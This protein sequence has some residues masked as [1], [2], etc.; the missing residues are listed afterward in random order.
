[1]EK[2]LFWHQGLFLQPQHLQLKDQFD[3][4]RLT[5]YHTYLQPYLAGVSGL[6]IRASSLRNGTFHVN[7]GAF[8]FDDMTYAVIGENAVI[9]PRGF[10][11]VWGEGGK[12]LTVYIGI[13]RYDDQG[14]NVASVPSGSSLYDLNTR[15][16]TGET[17][18]TVNDLHQGGS[19]AKVKK[20]SCLL[21]IFFHPE[22]ER[23]GSY[24]LI[25]VAR[26]ERT[27]E[28]IRLSTTYVPPS[29]SINGSSLLT[30]LVREVL[31]Q[32]T[33]RGHELELHKKKRGIHNAEFG[34][35]D[36]VY[37]LALMTFNRYIPL[38]NHFLDGSDIHPWNV[39][40]ALRQ[41]IGELSSFSD[42]IDVHGAEEKGSNHLKEY[43]HYDLWTCFSGALGLISGLIDEI[44]AGPEYVIPFA[45][46]D[47]YYSMQLSPE[48]FDGN[49]HYYLVIRTNEDVK[50][51]LD[52]VDIG[53]KLSS[54][55]LLPVLVERSLPGAALE[56]IP[57]PPQELPRRSDFIYFK[58][59]SQC[60][61][62]AQVESDKTVS[63]YWEFPPEDMG[64][65][66]MIVRRR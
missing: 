57:S 56:Y 30:G 20:L 23:L 48:H 49:N 55:K 51:V 54:G 31:D 26:I 32:I 17:P 5:P 50:L 40:A 10:K 39:Y 38:F 41:L 45:S 29:I 3:H 9:E 19:P 66:L 7:R 6:E 65:E 53:V 33:F 59:D 43:D 14:I 28:D 64:M 34:S 4:Y 21:K 44:T 18:E 35:R 8:W 36:M 25:P 24:E 42:T 63:V 58:V 22:K 15:Y 11:D 60:E 46:E 27:G 2:P 61:Q 37:L 16:I 1:M 12:P 52:A 62:W 13:K 47:P